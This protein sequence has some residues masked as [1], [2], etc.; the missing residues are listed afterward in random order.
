MCDQ[1]RYSY[2]VCGRGG[3]LTRCQTELLMCAE[4]MRLKVNEPDGLCIRRLSSVSTLVLHLG[5]MQPLTAICHE[6]TS[7]RRPTAHPASSA[8]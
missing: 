3:P 1:R 8:G 4:P 5:C 2:Q 6:D 7:C